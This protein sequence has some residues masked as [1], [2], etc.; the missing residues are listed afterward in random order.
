MKKIFSVLLTAAIAIGI[1]VFIGVYLYLP[2]YLKNTIEER[3]TAALGAPLNIGALGLNFMPLKVVIE[4]MA[5]SYPQQGLNFQI[6]QINIEADL[7]TLLNPTHPVLNIEVVRPKISVITLPE[8]KAP[9]K[10]SSQAAK[11]PAL[12]ISDLTLSFHL[13]E[14]SVDHPLMSVSAFH[15]DL[16]IH[17]LNS[18]P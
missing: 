1:I 7:K 5:G 15:L 10:T 17:S 13:K 3:G 18:I 12:P 16:E 4:Q 11:P 8:K 14:A 2:A 9:S 6:E